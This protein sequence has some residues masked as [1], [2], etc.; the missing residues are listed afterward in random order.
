MPGSKYGS[1]P[2]EASHEVQ[3]PR[4]ETVILSGDYVIRRSE[5]VGDEYSCE[6]AECCRR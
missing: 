4:S 1:S 5:S 2:R 3:K 6:K